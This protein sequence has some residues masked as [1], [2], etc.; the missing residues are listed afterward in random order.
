MLTKEQAIEFLTH[1][2]DGTYTGNLRCPGSRYGYN[3]AECA[4]VAYRAY[5]ALENEAGPADDDQETL[6]W[7]MGL[8]VNNHD[9]IAALIAGYTE[10]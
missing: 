7:L 10:E 2:Q 9:D 6:Y 4:D 1:D 3:G 8:T 5:V